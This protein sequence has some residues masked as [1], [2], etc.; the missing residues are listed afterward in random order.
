MPVISATQSS[1]A[2]EAYSRVANE[3]SERLR[4]QETVKAARQAAGAARVRNRSFGFS[5][6]KFGIDFTAQDVELDAGAL[7]RQGT[8][9][10]RESFDADLEAAA[11]LHTASA[12]TQEARADAPA[13]PDTSALTRIKALQAYAEASL[14][15]AAAAAVPGRRIGSV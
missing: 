6:G 7:A 9:P 15:G 11:I 3:R 5:V 1:Q 14:N 12:D 2:F 13:T 10:A 4:A 8:V